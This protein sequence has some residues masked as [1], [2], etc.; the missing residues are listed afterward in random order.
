M[1][2]GEVQVLAMPYEPDFGCVWDMTARDIKLRLR[3]TKGAE[4]LYA[5]CEGAWSWDTSMAAAEAQAGS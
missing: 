1:L 5:G 2:A 4:I 3:D